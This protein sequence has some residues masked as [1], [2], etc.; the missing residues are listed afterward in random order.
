MS[1]RKPVLYCKK[2]RFRRERPFL[3]EKE[4]KREELY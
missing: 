2:G 3:F 4:R 1:S